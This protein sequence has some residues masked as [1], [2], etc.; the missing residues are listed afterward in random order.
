[1]TESADIT[2]ERVD[3]SP[4]VVAQMRR[5]GLP[6]VLECHFPMQGH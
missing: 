3:D 1:M 6:V 4:L 2:T 5:M